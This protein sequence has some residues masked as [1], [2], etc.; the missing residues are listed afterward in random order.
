MLDAI[1]QGVRMSTTMIKNGTVVTADLTYKADVRIEGGV[2]TEIGQGLRGST[3]LAVERSGFV[4]AG[5][6]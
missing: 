5:F 4:V 1:E 2:I 3:G 6:A